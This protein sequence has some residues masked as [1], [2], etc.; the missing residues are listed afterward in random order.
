MFS[1]EQPKTS[2][3]FNG[4]IIWNDNVNQQQ[5]GSSANPFRSNTNNKVNGSLNN[6]YTTPAF[7][8]NNSS[9]WMPNPFMVNN[10]I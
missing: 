10:L 6:F 1:Q 7:P 2:N 9:P 4:S 3:P 8:T 5:V